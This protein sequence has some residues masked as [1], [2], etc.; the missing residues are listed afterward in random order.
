VIVAPL[1][2]YPA[3]RTVY[4]AKMHPNSRPPNRRAEPDE[5]AGAGIFAVSAGSKP[6]CPCSPIR[7]SKL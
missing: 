7:R 2:C 6:Y 1:Q 5:I 3:T 4:P